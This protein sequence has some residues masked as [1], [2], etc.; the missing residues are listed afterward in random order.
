MKQAIAA[1]KPDAPT[2]LAP[3]HGELLPQRSILGFQPALRL[4]ERDHHQAEG[5]E[6]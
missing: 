5:Q 2:H 1:S 6:D 3:Q 4:E